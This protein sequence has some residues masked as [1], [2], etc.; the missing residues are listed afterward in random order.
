MNLVGD[1]KGKNAI[2]IDDIIDSGGTLCHAAKNL[3][4]FGAKNVVAFATHGLFNGAAQKNMENATAL[5]K[6]IVTNSVP[7]KPWEK[8]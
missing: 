3:K 8:D 5:T 7:P 1:V 4:D 2:I 6:I